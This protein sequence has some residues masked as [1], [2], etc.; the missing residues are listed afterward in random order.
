MAD[1]TGKT[2]G[3]YEIRER[4]GRGGMAEVYKG[5]QSSLDRFVAVKVLHAFLLDEE[6]SKERFARE[7]RSVAALRH[8][9][10]VQ[11][12]DYDHQDDVYF[13]V[14]EYIDGPNLKTVLQDH[15]KAGTRMSL[16]RIDEIIAGIGGA[17]AYA[18]G[19]GM[20]H[21]DVKPQNIMFT[22]KGQ[23]LLTDFGIAKIVSSSNMSASGMMTGTPAYMSPEQGRAV[24]LDHRTDIY[25]LGVAL[26]EMVTGRVPYDADT[27]FAVV[28][29]H[30]TDPLPLPR[31]LDGSIPESLERVILKAMAKAPEDRYRTATELAAAAHEAILAAG[32]AAAAR[33]ALPAGAEAAQASAT[34]P[35]P[36]QSYPPAYSGL[37]TQPMGSDPPSAWGRVGGSIPPQSTPPPGA[38]VWGP[39]QSAHNTPPPG[40]PVW[41]AQSAHNTP[42][43]GA[44]PW[45]T[46]QSARNTPPS[47]APPWV[48][49][50]AAHGVGPAPGILPGG[51]QGQ[52]GPGANPRFIA[53]RAQR[54]SNVGWMVAGGL[55]AVMLLC[56]GGICILGSLLSSIGQEVAKENIPTVPTAV[57]I[58]V[59]RTAIPPVERGMD[60]PLDPA[61]GPPGQGP[62]VQPP[63][64]MKG[65]GQEPIQQPVPQHPLEPQPPLT[66][67]PP[68]GTPG[69]ARPREP[70]P[71]AAPGAPGPL[72]DDR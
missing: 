35:P 25:S 62:V 37:P 34:T 1:L 44:P 60:P 30:I 14:M 47:G 70:A 28:I 41:G 10:I 45:G 4:I 24:S 5:Y 71:G 50:N 27:P 38:P 46:P 67:P 39:P 31:S 58:E 2:L 29:K 63:A 64:P 42:P 19:E 3:R 72:E 11:V 23:P 12:F 6:G 33:P 7:A 51:I 13:M 15:V 17:L 48:V 9:N 32:N 21:R 49:P 56:V 53:T 66:P 40:A 55:L 20:I 65:G 16:T 8:P 57:P 68:Y 43:P 26:Y 59:I 61:Q 69:G 36:G 52:W 18:H 54:R 22:A